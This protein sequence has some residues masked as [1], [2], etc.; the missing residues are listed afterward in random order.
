MRWRKEGKNALREDERVDSSELHMG[1]TLLCG[2]RLGREL[3][4]T[5]GRFHV[6]PDHFRPFQIAGKRDSR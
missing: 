6:R 3:P 4:L 2:V 5:P 1:L